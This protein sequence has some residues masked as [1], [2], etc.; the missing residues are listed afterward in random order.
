MTIEI[1]TVSQ[2][3]QLSYNYKFQF[4]MEFYCILVFVRLAEFLRHCPV[5]IHSLIYVLTASSNVQ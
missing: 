1:I 3:A 4:L 5:R 2:A